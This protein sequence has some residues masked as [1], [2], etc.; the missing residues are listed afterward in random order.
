MIEID[1]TI[2]A[3]DLAPAAERVFSVA[4]ETQKGFFRRW[5]EEDGAPVF[6]DRGRYTSRGWTEW[7]QGF[8]Y[9]SAILT[10]DALGD[11]ELLAKGVE[12]T[13]RY[14]DPHLTHFGVH[15]HGFNNVSTYGNLLRLIREGR[16]EDTEWSRRF[17]ELAL[18]VSGAAQ[19]RR[20]VELPGEL[21][22]VASFNGLHSLFVD[23]IR[24]MRVLMLAHALGMFYW[25]EQDR[26]ESLLARALKHIETTFRYNLYWGEGRDIYDE[27]GRVVHESIFNLES[28]VYRCPST[29]QGYSPFST[30]TRGQAWLISG[31]AEELEFAAGL[32]DGEIAACGLPYFPDRESLLQRLEAAATVAADHFI[33]ST[34]P[35]G[36]PYW[37]TGAP[38]LAA[39]PDHNGRPADPCNPH[40]PVDSSAAAITAQGMLRLGSYLASRGRDGSRYTDCGLTI[41]RRLFGEPYLSVDP[42][43]EGLLLHAVYHR[44]NG[45]DAAPEG[46]T[47]P[48]GE[49]CQWGDYHLLELALQVRR[50]ARGE[51]PYTFYGCLEERTV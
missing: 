17:Y 5:K 8:V 44:S 33:R 4:A 7:T 2:A 34:P 30:W 12:G 38:G 18:K 25:G 27:P 51:K 29:Q 35:D 26:R 15:D 9:G 6:T 3:E 40:E 10:W 47:V 14:M 21:G 42:A 16:L 11:E 45:W 22:Y 19:A 37:D 23:T 41:A 32:S 13:L 1:T 39:L 20:F 24:S 43:H 49:A 48:A 50:T 31:A 46:S 28:R 36:I